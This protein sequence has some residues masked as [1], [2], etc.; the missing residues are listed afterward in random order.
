MVHVYVTNSAQVTMRFDTTLED[1]IFCNN[2]IF[3]KII[4]LLKNIFLQFYNNNGEALF[5]DKM[6][7]FL[8]ITMDRIRIVNIRQGSVIIDF[9]IDEP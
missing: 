4:N 3:T 9:L 5:V 2:L 7:A 8:G 1:V 6:V